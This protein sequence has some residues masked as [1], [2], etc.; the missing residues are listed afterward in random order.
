MSVV[1][2][3][4]SGLGSTIASVEESNRWKAYSTMAGGVIYMMYQGNM[5]ITGNI[6]LYVESYYKVGTKEASLMVPT[7]AFLSAFF[8]L[9]TVRFIQ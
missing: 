8:Q 9:F 5:S 7:I 1:S 2:S 4:L 3:R 6:Q